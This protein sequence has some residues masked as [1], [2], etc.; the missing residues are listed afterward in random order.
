MLVPGMILGAPFVQPV[1]DWANTR[2][3][4]TLGQNTVVSHGHATSV[5]D[6][7]RR[8]REVQA[9]GGALIVADPRQTETARLADLHLQIRP[10]SDAALA[11]F[12]VHQRLRTGCDQA[13]LEACADRQSVERLRGAVAPFDRETTARWCEVD[14]VVLDQVSALLEKEARLSFVSG[15]GVSMGPAANAVEWLGWALT[16]VSGSLDRKGGMLFNPG[17]LRPQSDTGPVAMERITGPPARSRPEFD[18]AYGEYPSAVLCD[19][20]LS[21]HVRAVL[22]FGGSIVGSFPDTEKTT[23][24]LKTLDVLAVAE[25]RHTQTT[26]LATH[27]LPTTDQLER[28]DVTYFLDQLFPVPFAQFTAPVVSPLGNRRPLW[29]IMGD[30]AAA[31]GLDM[32]GLNPMG[33]DEEVLRQVIKRSR[34]SI[35]DLQAAPSGVTVDDAPLWNW[36]IPDRVPKGKLDLAPDPLVREL[37]GWA[38]AQDRYGRTATKGQFSLICRRLPHQMNSDLQELPSQQR[39]PRATLLMS[40]LDAGPLGLAD[41]DP[42]E[43]SNEHG[44]TEA[45]LEV[46]DRIRP[47]VVS[48]PHSWRTPVVN[49]L[50]STEDL[51]PLTGMPR[52]T[53]IP[54]SVRP[55][56][57]L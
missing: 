44:S 16:A 35:E 7:V 53:A 15:T 9:R 18:H 34:V 38:D 43:V 46:T 22:S 27:V 56:T 54:V 37:H 55:A 28:A 3:I 17:V 14:P 25:I 10:G 2:L 49:R 45:V 8:I 42:V 32:G 6:P 4:I 41:G 29:R 5:S 21:G 57:T 47:G 39:A 50:T 13:Y 20:I 24:A 12:L 52:Y 31:M 19:E 36:L 33:D 30:L 11:A 40:P 48:L 26:A 1:V 23:R 51:D